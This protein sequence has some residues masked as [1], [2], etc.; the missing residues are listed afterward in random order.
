MCYRIIRIS[1][2]FLGFTE[3]PSQDSASHDSSHNSPGRTIL[4][5]HSLCIVLDTDCE[6][7]DPIQETTYASMWL[8]LCRQCMLAQSQVKCFYFLIP[9]VFV[10]S[11]QTTHSLK[12]QHVTGTLNKQSF[13]SCLALLQ[14]TLYYKSV[15]LAYTL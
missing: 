3:P 1:Q 5:V 9:Y 11:M 4:H 14:H 6:S 12:G 15:S 13:T 2:Q 8:Q 10:H 7:Q